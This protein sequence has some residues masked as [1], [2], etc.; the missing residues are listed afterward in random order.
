MNY[1][2]CLETC[3]TRIGVEINKEYCKLATRRIQA[4]VKSNP[5]V[6]MKNRFIQEE[7]HRMSLL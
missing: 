4:Y 1:R 6:V 3:R 5:L 7:A 2:A